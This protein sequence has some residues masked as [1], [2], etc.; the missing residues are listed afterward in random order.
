MSK[1]NE[2]FIALDLPDGILNLMGQDRSK[3]IGVSKIGAKKIDTEYFDRWKSCDEEDFPAQFVEATALID[4]LTGLNKIENWGFKVI[5]N[6]LVVTKNPF[7]SELYII[8]ANKHK[9]LVINDAALN[10][11]HSQY[12]TIWFCRLCTQEIAAKSPADKM[13]GENFKKISNLIASLIDEGLD[14]HPDNPFR[15]Y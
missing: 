12:A 14:T 1:G 9:N 10:D 15:P 2:G 4:I 7:N 13:Q 6:H 3:K 8:I 11:H 5:D